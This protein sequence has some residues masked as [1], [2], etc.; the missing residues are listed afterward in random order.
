MYISA[1]G[2]VW[3]LFSPLGGGGHSALGDFFGGGGGGEAYSS[4]GGGGGDAGG[5]GGGG[6]GGGDAGGSGGGAWLHGLSQG[7]FP[8]LFCKSPGGVSS[9]FLGLKPLIGTTITRRTRKS[10][11]PNIFV[12][13]SWNFEHFKVREFDGR[14]C[15]GTMT[16]VF[17]G[18]VE[19]KMSCKFWKGGVLCLHF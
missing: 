1:E 9:R 8:H 5:G 4:G 2:G 19:K 16:L 7:Q 14:L 11:T 13:K 18:G 15:L 17:G 3:G 6:G 10:L 12:P